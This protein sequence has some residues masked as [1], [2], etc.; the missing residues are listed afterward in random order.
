M[1][2]TAIILLTC[3]L[4]VSA[5]VN[6][7]GITL[8]VENA[9]LNKVFQEIKKQTG[10]TFMYAQTMLRESNNVSMDVKNITLQ[11]A[12]TICFAN[13]PFTYKIINK[14]VVV[15]PKEKTSQN[16]NLIE[17]SQLKEAPELTVKGNVT[18]AATGEPLMGVTVTVKGSKI[19]T[20]TDANGKFSLDV[21]NDAVLEV[22]SIGYNKKEIAVNSRTTINISLMKSATG[23]SQVV[24]TG[25]ESQR[26]ADLIG[27]V[28]VV[29]LNDIKN[30]PVSSPLQALQGQ[31]AGLHITKDGTPGGAATSVLV[32]GI[33]TLGNNDPLYIVDG[34]PVGSMIVERLNPYDIQSLQVLKDAA[35]ASIYGSRASNGVIIITTKSANGNSFKVDF[36]SSYTSQH[37]GKHLEMLNTEERGRVAWQAAINDGTDPNLNTQYQFKW[38]NDAQGNPVLDKVLINEWLDST[39]QGGEKSANTD[40][41]KEISRPGFLIRNNVSISSGSKMHSIYFSLEHLYNKGVV[42]YTNNEQYNFRLNSDFK[43]LKGKLKFGEN[44]Q[45][46][47][48]TQTPLGNVQGGT[49]LSFAVIDLPIL[50]VYAEDGSFAGPVGSGFS[51]R[52]S[53]LQTAELT[54]DWKNRNKS[55]YGNLY[56]EFSPITN[57]R[58]RSLLGIDYGLNQKIE[59]NPTFTAGFL[60]QLVNNY[61]NDL[62]QEFN[63]TWTNTLNYSFKTKKHNLDILAGTEAI[64]SNLNNMSGYKEGFLIET[65]AY[66]Q[67]DA[68]TGLTT[69]T[70]TESGYQLLS[71]FTKLNY[72]YN[73]KYLLSFTLRSDGS[74]RFGENNKYGLFPAFSAGWRISDEDFVKD[75][76]SFISHL[77]LRYGMGKTGNQKI[78]NDAR[79]GLFVPGYGLISSRTNLGSAYDLNGANLGTLPSGVIQ[80]QTANPN[81]KW[82]FT[83]EIN[84]GT[85]F[86]FLNQKIT[87]SFDY[88]IRNTSNILIHPPQLAVLGSGG[89]IWENGATMKN[90]GWEFVLG[91]ENQVRD[92]S[93]R[94]SANVGSSKDKVTY[95]PNSVVS[96]YPG[97]VEKTILGHSV[98]SMFGYV[99]DGIF[100]SQA[101]VD[102]AAQQT[103]KGVGRIRYKDLNGDGVINV[104]DQTWLGTSLPDFEYGINTVLNY[105]RFQLSFFIQGVQGLMLSNDVRNQATFFGYF[106][107]QNNSTQILKAWTPQNPNTD[108][109]AVSNL[110]QNDETRVSTYQIQNASYI[111]LKNARLAY[112]LPQKMQEKLRMN[113]ALIY[114]S[115]SELFTI[116]SKKFSSPD[117]ENPGYLYPIVQS[118]TIGLHVSF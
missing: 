8:N 19:G 76:L 84:V 57:L 87:G 109:P 111:K 105:K 23:L 85:D 10:Y 82:E 64:K 44:L 41:F 56:F 54:K 1:K 32:R 30:L 94:I 66:F 60:S 113:D 102:K 67:M 7:Q 45:I 103:G 79:F 14:T 51:N 13:Q 29:N 55:V 28:A 72:R 86:G 50:P 52:L 3:C 80:T 90:K 15:Q 108:I 59:I 24:I 97:N 34:Q 100:Q 40:W 69:L 43:V 71:Y 116:K 115:G 110:T 49:P 68:G 78:A 46:T 9:P 25:Y 114:I 6:S 38:H 20:A 47:S 65:P 18:D 92:F 39:T 61:S 31:V 93:Y 117:P 96:A 101:E 83:D 37:Y 74:S 104:L 26:K 118:F 36:N 11:K 99:A 81:L 98:T 106:F 58:F 53:A 88:F 95:L 62:N 16:N 5:K 33:N 75:N 73:S 77:M 63:W 2:F 12:L 27:A 70:G 22:S 112:T 91:F 42:K 35:S 89:N 17:V 4:Q 21:P 107:G 48:G